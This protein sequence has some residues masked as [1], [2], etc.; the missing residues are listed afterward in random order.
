M[1]LCKN[2]NQITTLKLP[3]YGRIACKLREVKV[4]VPPRGLSRLEAKE[5]LQ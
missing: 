1:I 3:R 4:S 5:K 2:Y